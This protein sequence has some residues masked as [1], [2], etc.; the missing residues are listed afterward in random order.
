MI[1][2]FYDIL[3]SVVKK[4]VPKFFVKKSMRVIMITCNLT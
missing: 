4:L 3:I 2:D 1:S